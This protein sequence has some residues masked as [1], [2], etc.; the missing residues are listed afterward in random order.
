MAN[1]PFDNA[2]TNGEHTDQNTT[3]SK[4]ENPITTVSDQAKIVTTLKGGSGFDAP[5]TVIHADNAADALE[6]LNDPQLE[7]LLNRTQKVGQFFANQGKPS[8]KA[9]GGSG[10]GKPAG[11]EQA[12]AGS[13]EC[14]PGWT[15]KS[16]VSKKGKAWKAYMPPRDSDESPI[17]L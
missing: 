15:F 4:K 13:P 1:D 2:P 16:G 10:N 3:D 5:W 7:E 11:A 14:P 6:V 9:N 17:W 12:P 8:G